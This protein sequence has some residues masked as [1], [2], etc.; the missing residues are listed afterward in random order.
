MVTFREA[1]IF[2]NQMHIIPFDGLRNYFSPF[3]EAILWF[4]KDIGQIGVGLFFLIS[5]FV[6]PISIEKYGSSQFL[7]QRFFRLYPVLLFA[8]LIHFVATSLYANHISE[9]LSTYRFNILETIVMPFG[10][11]EHFE[12]SGSALKTVIWTLIIEFHFYIIT[13]IAFFVLR[14]KHQNLQRIHI[15]LIVVIGIVCKQQELFVFNGQFF[16]LPIGTAFYLYSKGRL[17]YKAPELF[18]TCVALFLIAG[19]NTEYTIALLIWIAFFLLKDQIKR[20]PTLLNT[21]AAISYPLY[22]LHTIAYFT[23]SVFV[24][25]GMSILTS[26]AISL[27][28]IFLAS[29]ITNLHIERRGVLLG[30]KLMTK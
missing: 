5:G 15:L 7:I 17:E 22:L 21:V 20:V 1:T 2:S 29:Y 27:S 18:I 11:K 30:E 13:A 6:I 24:N 28:F 8:I 23:M 4:P 25:N 3:W 14:K 9:P 16:I 10:Y 26:Y 19:P 12:S